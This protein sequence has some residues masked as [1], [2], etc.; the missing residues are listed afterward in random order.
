[1]PSRTDNSPGCS[2]YLF[3]Y[4]YV[5][6]PLRISSVCRTIHAALTGPKAKKHAGVQEDLLTDAWGRLDRYWRDLDNL[7]EI[8]T[9]DI[10]E[11]DDME[12]FIHGWQVRCTSL[13]P[14]GFV[15][16]LSRNALGRYSFS[17]AVSSCAYRYIL[18]NINLNYR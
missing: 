8:G 1:M 18:R 17:S 10:I 5:A 13:L 11:V 7:R 3:T 15:S 16:F 12:R 4:R 9:A 2:I 6:V 14:D